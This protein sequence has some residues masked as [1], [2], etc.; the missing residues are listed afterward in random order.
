MVRTTHHLEVKSNC[1]VNGEV[2]IYDV[3][4]MTRQVIPVETILEVVADLTSAPIFQEDLTEQ[5]AGRL[6]VSVQTSGCHSGVMAVC[7]S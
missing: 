5:L 1:P 7:W 6:G 2:D 4:I 3:R